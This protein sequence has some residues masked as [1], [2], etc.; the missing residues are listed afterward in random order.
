MCEIGPEMYVEPSTVVIE[1]KEITY[2][3]AGKAPPPLP[4]IFLICLYNY[5]QIVE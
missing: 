5:T 2:T 4:L 3:K 1:G